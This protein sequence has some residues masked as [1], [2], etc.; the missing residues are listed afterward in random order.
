MDRATDKVG[1]SFPKGYQS[2]LPKA[3]PLQLWFVQRPGVGWAGA[4]RLCCGELVRGLGAEGAE[5]N[6]SQ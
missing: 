6:I 2:E 4:P 3:R 5:G 1:Q